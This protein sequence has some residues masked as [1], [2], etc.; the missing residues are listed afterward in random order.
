M[1]TIPVEKRKAITVDQKKF[2]EDLEVYSNRLTTIQEIKK[3]V[4]KYI[5]KFK[6][7]NDFFSDILN[8]FYSGLLH[9]YKKENTLNLRAEKLAELLEFDLRKLKELVAN[10]DKLK[11]VKSPTIENYTTYTETPEQLTRKEQCEKLINTIYE[12]E[13]STG[14]KAYPFDVTK[15]FRRILDFNI[16]TNKFQ[17]NTYWVKT[18]RQI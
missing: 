2:A 16:R 1:N 4:K 14:V 12:V 11:D 3:E 18:G 10:Y 6:F 5:P 15:A 17:A 8:N 7:N 9:K 13:E